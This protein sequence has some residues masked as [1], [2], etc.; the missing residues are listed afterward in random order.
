VLEVTEAVRHAGE[1]DVWT[2]PEKDEVLE[3]LTEEGKDFVGKYLAKKVPKAPNHPTLASHISLPAIPTPHA[4]QSYNPT[5]ET[6]AALLL[7]EHEKE[8]VRQAEYAKAE[9]VQAKLDEV[10]ALRVGEGIGSGAPGMKVD[11]AADDEVPEDQEEQE[12]E[13]VVVTSTVPKRKTRQQRARA[14][15]QLADLRA[16][17]QQKARKRL[18]ASLSSVASLSKALAAR[19]AAAEQRA[20]ERAAAKL[21]ALKNGLAGRRLGKHK[22]PEA[23]VDLQL[24]D[25]LAE[26]LREMKPEGNLFRERWESLQQRARVEPRVLVKGREKRLK[27]KTREVH[28]YKRFV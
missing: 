24:G 27:V 18:L 25:E 20:S 7:Q 21:A 10:R 1:Y 22:V 3:S 13:V 11:G 19:Q 2:A 5:L 14:A 26:T 8:V 6:H 15:K 16:L 4:G 12:Q 23:R 28:R 17:Q 9:A